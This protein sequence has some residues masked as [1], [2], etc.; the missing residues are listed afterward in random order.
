M[1]MLKRR[2][3][4]GRSVLVLV[5]LLVVV[6]VN[7][8]MECR[9]GVEVVWEERFEVVAGN[10]HRGPWRMNE[11]NFDF[12]DDPGVAIDEVGRV[13]VVYADHSVLDIFSSSMM[14]KAMSALMRW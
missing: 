1:I 2:F 10:A 14:W 6:L 11:S 8:V 12:V 5:V 13:G 7:P 3:Q 4:P 9:G